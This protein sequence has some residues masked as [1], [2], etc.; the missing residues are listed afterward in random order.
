VQVLLADALSLKINIKDCVC[1]ETMKMS[2]K[3]FDYHNYYVHFSAPGKEV[4]NLSITAWYII[5]AILKLIVCR[6]GN[7]LIQE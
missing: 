2:L 4:P 3:D 6:K 5:V 1:K 7:Q